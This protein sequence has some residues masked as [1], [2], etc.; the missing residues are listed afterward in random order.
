MDNSV[1]NY[2][3]YIS[4]EIEY[5]ADWMDS[6]HYFSNVQGVDNLSKFTDEF[7]RKVIVLKDK[8][9][10]HIVNQRFSE[11]KDIVVH[12]QHPIKDVP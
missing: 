5:N 2:L 9:N 4:T 10:Y 8:E 11:R 6:T 7:G 12:C 1:F 3:W